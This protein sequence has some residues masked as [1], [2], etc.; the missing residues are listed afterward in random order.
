MQ[1]FSVYNNFLYF[2]NYSGYLNFLYVARFN[3]MSPTLPI[4]YRVEWTEEWQAI[5]GQSRETAMEGAQTGA[6]LFN[7]CPRIEI[8]EEVSEAGAAGGRL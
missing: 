5:D 4:A 7:N 1:H 3:S 2:L 8:V 6:K